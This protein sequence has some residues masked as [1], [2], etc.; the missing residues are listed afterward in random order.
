MAATAS[1][2]EANGATPTWT[3]ITSARFCSAD[4]YNPGTSYPIR[5]PSSGTN[6]SYWKTWRLKFT[7]TYT[8]ITNVKIYTDGSSGYGTGVTTYIG[9]E[10]LDSSAYEQATGTQGTTGDE[11]VAN[12]SGITAKTDFF[13]YTSSNMKT[14]DTSTITGD[15]AYS[16]LIIVQQAIAST[17]SS[18]VTSSETFTWQYDEI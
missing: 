11:L 7:G 16:K 17:A 14:V 4:S 1:V 5:V 12:H 9:D 3:T 15:P 2:E 18:G 13:T 8:Q 6:Y 10:T